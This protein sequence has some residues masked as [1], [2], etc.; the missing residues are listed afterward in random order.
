M[1]F[2]RKTEKRV[3]LD[4]P[5]TEIHTNPNQPRQFFDPASI[6]ELSDSIRQHGIIQPLTVRKTPEGWQLISG[7]R[8]MRAAGLAGLQTVPCL[9]LDVSTE[10]SSFLALI[11]N[12]QRRDLNVWEEAEA[13][14]NLI[15]QYKLSQEEAA[16]LIGKSQSAVANKLRLLKLP[17][18]VI[19]E[20][21][22]ASLSERHARA[23]LR[24]ESPEKQRAALHHIIEA[25]LNVA[26]TDAYI[27]RILAQPPKKR[28]KPVYRCKDIRLFLNTIQHSLDIMKSAGVAADC[29]RSETEDQI[30]LTIRIPKT[31]PNVS[32]ETSKESALRA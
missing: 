4:L 9:S 28:A 19:K 26:Q 2:F 18:D 25:N 22:S 23:L 14:Q 6:Q 29:G 13:I 17:N 10:E 32:H 20:I 5:I 15:E 12:V 16:A 30:I 1:A 8:R 24:L 31:P 21:Q 3:V 11:E 7:E 27:Q